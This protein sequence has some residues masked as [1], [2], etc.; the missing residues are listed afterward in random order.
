MDLGLASDTYI[1]YNNLLWALNIDD[2]RAALEL[3]DEAL[4]LLEARGLIEGQALTRAYQLETLFLLGRWREVLAQADDIIAWAYEQTS[5]HVRLIASISKAWAMSLAGREIEAG[6]FADDLCEGQSDRWLTALAVPRIR[7][8]RAR[9]QAG[10]AA[11]LLQDTIEEFEESRTP[12]LE[13]LPDIAREAVALGRSDLLGR[14]GPLTTGDVKCAVH[15]GKT[16]RGLSAETD[17]RHEE[18]REAF[19]RAATGWAS[20]GNPYELAQAHL[21]M[22]RCLI[23]LRRVSEASASLRKARRIF[24]ALGAAPALRETDL[25]SRP[26]VPSPGKLE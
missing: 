19:A 20:F 4:K 5:W 10:D 7:G 8:R 16:W 13:F 25:V 23:E 22:A 15:G 21:G 18:A 17:H 11:D 14:C 26:L 6:Q 12:L 3:A 24:S 1:T 2:P 9:G